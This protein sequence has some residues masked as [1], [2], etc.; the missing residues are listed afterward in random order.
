[1]KQTLPIIFILIIQNFLFGQFNETIRTGRP[2]QAIGPFTLG[3][4]VIQIQSGIT[5]NQIEKELTNTNS[6]L[7]NTVIRF[8]IL[9]KF[10]ISGVI[11]WQ[12][13][14]MMFNGVKEKRKGISDTQFG[15]RINILER[16]GPIPAIGL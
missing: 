3:G 12:S 7:K 10:E 16:K 5:F 15:G 9:E 6:F 13:E 14:N 11:N 1:M 2:G 8:G 4:K